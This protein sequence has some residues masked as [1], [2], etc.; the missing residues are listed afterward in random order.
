MKV[1]CFFLPPRRICGSASARRGTTHIPWVDM[2]AGMQHPS[3]DGYEE[4]GVLG[5]G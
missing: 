5:R 4:V 3:L 1:P 2:Q